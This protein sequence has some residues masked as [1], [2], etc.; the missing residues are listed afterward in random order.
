M[1]TLRY[2]WFMTL[3]SPSYTFAAF[4]TRCMVWPAFTFF[5]KRPV[6]YAISTHV[7]NVYRRLTIPNSHL[8]HNVFQCNRRCRHMCTNWQHQNKLLHS[9]TG[10][11]CI[12]WYLQE[13]YQTCEDTKSQLHKHKHGSVA[14]NITESHPRLYV[15]R[16]RS[17]FWGRG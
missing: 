5:G 3:D 14:P 4:S 15:F 11:C 12:R 1:T 8:S 7:L 17:C 6:H 16:K 10:C 2:T 9:Y 13:Q